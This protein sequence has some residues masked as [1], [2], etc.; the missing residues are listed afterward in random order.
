MSLLGDRKNT[1]NTKNTKKRIGHMEGNCEDILNFKF[2]RIWGGVINPTRH[3][4]YGNRK[5]S[6][7]RIN[8]LRHPR[9]ILFREYNGIFLKGDLQKTNYVIM[10][11]I[12]NYDEHYLHLLDYVK[13]VFCVCVCVCL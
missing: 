5:I 6:S 12:S 11:R 3:G 2:K 9:I 4:S 7:D 10:P 1:K 13:F 8:H